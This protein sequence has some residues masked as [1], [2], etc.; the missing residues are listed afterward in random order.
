[1][2]VLREIY[3]IKPVDNSRLV[4]VAD[5][6]Q[7][8][9]FLSTTVLAALV[10]VTVMGLAVAR[11][12]AIQNGYQLEVLQQE[13]QALLEA[14]RKLRLEEASLVDPVRIDRIARTQLGM[15]PLSA[16][17]IVWGEADSATPAAAELAQASSPGRALLL[18]PAKSVAAAVP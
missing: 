8:R 2:D 17:Q 1:M 9:Q 10:F 16:H 15:R 3:Y 6:R 7:P 4:P 13:K 14:N 18:S 11:L 12:A 5:P